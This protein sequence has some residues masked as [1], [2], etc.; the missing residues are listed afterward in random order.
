[1]FTCPVACLTMMVK[2]FC[3]C[4]LAWC[5]FVSLLCFVIPMVFVDVLPVVFVDCNVCACMTVLVLCV[6]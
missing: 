5:S 2:V 1:M 3:Q 4:Y 6:L